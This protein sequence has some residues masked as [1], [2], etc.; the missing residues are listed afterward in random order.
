LLREANAEA[1]YLKSMHP[2]FFE[3]NN[4]TGQYQLR[5]F[6]SDR[7][8]QQVDCA[9]SQAFCWEAIN[10]WF[11]TEA[12]G[13]QAYAKLCA[14]LYDRFQNQSA[15]E[16]TEARRVLCIQGPSSAASTCEPLARQVAE[17]AGN[18]SDCEAVTVSAD[19]SQI[20]TVCEPLDG[21]SSSGRSQRG[22]TELVLTF[23]VGLL[24]LNQFNLL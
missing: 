23:V 20:P 21:T 9:Q 11:S 13:Q 6:I 4:S 22:G 18:S 16:Q 7:L 17:V 15:R 24:A 5:P 1:D 2:A 3:L 8:G 14:S 12:D 10:I 19:A